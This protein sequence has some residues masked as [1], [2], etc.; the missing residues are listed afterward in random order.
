MIKILIIKLGALGDVLRTTPILNAIKEKYPDSE[1][2]WV[3]RYDSTE[4]LSNNPKINKVF[5]L[6]YKNTETFDILYNFDIEKEAIKLA[7]SIQAKEKYGFYDNN[8]YPAAF[9]IAA[10]Y[11]LNT[12]FDDELKKN[13]KKTYQEMIFEVAELSYE[14]Q[15]IQLNLSNDD[16]KYA[17][18]FI[19]E[20]N[21]K[22][23]NLIGI[24]IGASS[25]WP[26]KAWSENKIK[27]F[28]KELKGRGN[29]VILFSGLNEKDKHEKIMKELKEEGFQVYHNNPN[30]SIKQFASLVNSCKL[31]VCSDSFSLHIS[32]ALGIKT[33]ALF[34]CTS[35]NEIEGYG[36]LKKIISPLLYEFF[37][38][39]MNQYNEELVN[40]ISV[41]EVLKVFNDIIR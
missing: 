8:G 37:P 39:K 20:N 2:S 4:I 26:S 24:H 35:S 23:E 34:F 28:T 31:M 29:N 10:E 30:N 27:E 7:S 25:R 19:K 33:I 22:I 12:L 38:E 11:Y 18:N 13:N 6:P 32:L 17:E 5:T 16:K 14:K 41:K 21:I 1:I 36:L 40:S 9:N 15:L 3:T